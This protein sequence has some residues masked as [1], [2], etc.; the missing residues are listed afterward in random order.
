MQAQWDKIFDQVCESIKELQAVIDSFE[1][2]QTNNS[3]IIIGAIPGSQTDD[4][5][6]IT[7]D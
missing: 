3:D 4:V 7:L 1:D 6:Y 5:D 2:N